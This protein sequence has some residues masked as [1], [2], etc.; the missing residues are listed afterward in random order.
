MFIKDGIKFVQIFAGVIDESTP[1]LY[2]SALPFSPSESVMAR[3]LVQRFPGIAKVAQGQHNEW[4]RICHVLQGHKSGV[5]SVACSPD[6]RHIVSGSHDGTI[7]IWDAQIGRQ[8]GN[9]LKGHTNSVLSVAFS[10]DGRYIVSGSNDQT[11]QV[12]DAQTGDCVGNL[13]KG[14]TD[15]KGLV[16][17]S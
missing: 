1:H 14:H 17:L 16:S 4:S 6:G 11:L 10:P 2:L 7:R 8:V 15:F 13:L 12:W 5:L 9:P 3:Y